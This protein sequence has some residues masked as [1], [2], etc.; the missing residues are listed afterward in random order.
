MVDRGVA[1]RADLFVVI[2]CDN[3]FIVIDFDQFYVNCD[4]L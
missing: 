4:R 3:V 2:L 1:M